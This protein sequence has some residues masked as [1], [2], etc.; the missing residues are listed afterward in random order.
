MTRPTL[1]WSLVLIALLLAGCGSPAATPP[2]SPTFSLGPS[3]PTAPAP[4]ATPDI[5]RID[6]T[7][8]NGKVIFGYQGW[9]ACPGDGSPA[10]MWVHW[11]RNQ[12]P[13]EVNLTVDLWPDMTE[14]TAAERCPTQMILPDGSPL[15]AYSSY[16][17]QTVDR[18]FQWM[19]DYGIDGV[20]LQRFLSEARDPRF[21]EFRNGMAARV[22][23]AAE[24]HGRVFFVEFDGIDGSGAVDRLIRDWQYLVDEL[25]LTD[26]PSY[27]H[28]NGLPVVGMF[29]FGLNVEGGLPPDEAL[30]LLRYLQQDAPPQYRATVFGGVPSYWRTGTGDAAPDPAWA[31]VFR[32]FDVLS[33]WAVGRYGNQAEADTYRDQVTVPDLAEA[34]ASGM[35]Y[36]PVIFPG[37]SW[38]NLYPGEPSNAIPRDA[39][40]FYWRQAYNAV[41]AGAQ[42]IFVA[43]FDEVDEGTAMFKL[44]ATGDQLPP[45][46]KLVP[47]TVDG[48]PLPSDWYLRLGGETG[49]LLR[50]EIP[51]SP[52]MPF[53]VPERGITTP[54]YTLRV[55]LS[56]TSDWTTLDFVDADIVLAAEVVEVEGSPTGYGAALS[57][58]TLNQPLQ[59]AESGQQ[60]GISVRLLVRADAAATELHLLLQRGSLNASRVRIFQD[61]GPTQTLLLDQAHSRIVGTEGRN[62]V[63][64]TVDLSGLEKD[65]P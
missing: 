13:Y 38:A 43:M 64:L 29:G 48:Y 35:D 58:L 8:L 40:R 19:Q 6:A 55:D 34:N 17:A 41:S 32:S 61:L 12:N 63:E 47:L 42:M 65:S 18:H 24:G 52:E 4:T 49:R 45:R 31:E 11:F 15:Q 36:M 28:H 22:R 33:P 56:T 27:L 60:V 10:D 1:T 54:T 2:P 26:S 59:A 20:A 30:R 25:K 39:G 51:L 44:T 57:G 23:Q 7:T 3:T 46:S 14:V 21:F 5:P 9:F 37:F 16:N 62:P 50:G 53:P